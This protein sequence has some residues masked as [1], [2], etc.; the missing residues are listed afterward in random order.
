MIISY[1]KKAYIAN[2]ICLSLK[3]NHPITQS[4]AQWKCEERAVQ[5]EAR[6][7]V[8]VLSYREQGIPGM[9]L[10]YSA[11][12][13]LFCEPG[14]I[15]WLGISSP[16]LMESCQPNI[17]FCSEKAWLVRSQRIVGIA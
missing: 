6:K 12:N 10:H 14:L 16:H 2:I 11:Q 9:V 3:E 8:K 7:E 4:R 15:T 5:E 13:V 1:C 17:S